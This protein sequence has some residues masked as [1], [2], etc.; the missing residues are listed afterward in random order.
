MD[1]KE[2]LLKEMWHK[3]KPY[4]QGDGNRWRSYIVSQNEAALLETEA[5]CVTIVQ[6]PDGLYSQ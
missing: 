6:G 1:D 2:I 5:D 3:W 4:N